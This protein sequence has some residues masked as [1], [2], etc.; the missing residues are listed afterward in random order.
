MPALNIVLHG[1]KRWILIAESDHQKLESILGR[2]V[3]G[4]DLLLSTE[5]LKEKGIPYEEVIV[6]AGEGIF[7]P[8]GVLH[9]VINEADTIAVAFNVMLP[10]TLLSAWETLLENQRL[11]AL[12]KRDLSKVRLHELIFRLGRHISQ[13]TPEAQQ[14]KTSLTEDR[15]DDLKQTVWMLIQQMRE[16]ENFKIAGGKV[17]KTKLKHTSVCILNFVL[18][19]PQVHV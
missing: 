7:V 19:E 16:R 13:N 5:F 4:E 2:N 18:P 10:E 14:L 11:G 1:S 9:S 6:K 15:F 17:K 12:L 3:L 8:S